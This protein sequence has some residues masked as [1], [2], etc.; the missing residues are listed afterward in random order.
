M[1]HVG[2]ASLFDWVEI[3]VDDLVEILCDSFRDLM[4]SF[5]IEFAAFFLYEFTQSNGSKIADC[6]FVLRGILHDLSAEIR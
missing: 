5:V 1:A 3:P 4:E 6:N 2:V